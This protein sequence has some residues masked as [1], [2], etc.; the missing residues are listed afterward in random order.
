MCF[1]NYDLGHEIIYF[2]I[3]L[4]FYQIPYFSYSVDKEK[5]YIILILYIVVILFLSYHSVYFFLH[6][7]ENK[8]YDPLLLGFLF[9]KIFEYTILS[10]SN[11]NPL[12]PIMIVIYVLIFA[13]MYTNFN[14]LPPEDDE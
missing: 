6:T 10:Y 13:Y 2:A 11:K 5:K 12:Y 3:A 1:C 9:G 8:N 7:Y 4:Y 14:I